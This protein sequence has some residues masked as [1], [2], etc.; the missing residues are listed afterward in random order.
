MLHR[1]QGKY[2]SMIKSMNEAPSSYRMTPIVKIERENLNK[3]E[4]H[5]NLDE[6][7][8]AIR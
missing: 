5:D 3:G 1:A 6:R 8:R 4:I 2:D 7:T